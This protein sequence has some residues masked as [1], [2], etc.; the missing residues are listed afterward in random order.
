[1]E[2]DVRTILLNNMPVAQF[3]A[4]YLASL[5][6]AFVWFLIKL[7]KGISTDRDTPQQFQW[8][9][10]WR[11]FLKFIIS[12]LVLPW[13]VIYFPDYG[14]FFLKTLFQ[15]PDVTTDELNNVVME[16]NAGSAAIIG[17]FIDMG[18]RKLTHHKFKKLL[19]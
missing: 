14:P 8:K 13:V 15:F 5:F 9:Y 16:M 17:F 6:G 11:G 3:V 2:D 7:L 4:Y 18:I 12:V 1:M 19:P 10:F